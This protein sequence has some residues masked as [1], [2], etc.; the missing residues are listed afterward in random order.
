MDLNFDPLNILVMASASIVVSS[1]VQDGL[2]TWIQGFMLMMAYF[3]IAT[4]YWFMP[5]EDAVD[6][7]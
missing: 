4:L 7:L 1:T 5:N 3:I 6:A 2:G